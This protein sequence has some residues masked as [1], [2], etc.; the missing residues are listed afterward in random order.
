MVPGTLYEP[1]GEGVLWWSRYTDKARGRGEASLLDRCTA[2]NTCP[3]NLRDIGSA[4]FNAR[5]MTVALAGTDGKAD[6]PV[7]ANVRRYYFPGTT[8][9]GDDEGGFSAKPAQA[10]PAVFSLRTQIPKSRP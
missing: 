3:E 7:P 9:G 2:T 6:L 4:E 5:L 8:H 1:G 10:S